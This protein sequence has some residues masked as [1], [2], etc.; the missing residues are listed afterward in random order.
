M[1]RR[2]RGILFALTLLVAAGGLIAG[3]AS[4]L[5]AQDG[6][7]RLRFAT[8]APRD[9]PVGREFQALDRELRERSNDRVRIRLYAGGAAGDERTV[10]RKLRDGQLDGAMLTAVGLGAIAREVLILQAPGL[11]TTY[12][13]L[14]RVRRRLRPELDA[15]FTR[16][17][18]TMLGWGDAGRIRLFSTQ[19]IERPADLRSARPWVWRD[20]AT[21]GAFFRAAG[22][23]GVPLGVMEVLPALST[24]MVDTVIASSVSAIA[25]QWHG[26]LRTMSRQASGVVVGGVVIKTSALA[27]IPEDLRTYL[28]E[29]S[30]SNESEFRRAGRRLDA[31]AARELSR[32]LTVVD[33]DGHR[34]A[35][36]AVAERARQ[37]LVGRLYTQAQVDR[38]RAIL[39]EP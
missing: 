5:D 23:S 21:M 2:R 37:E 24:G 16:E 39:E 32:R 27:Q 1:A 13:E 31:R 26:R 12:P 33:L 10:V 6:P 15:A 19:T 35:W 17:G 34:T 25:M 29:Q 38:V 9:S 28:R 3:D 8:L 18:F 14:D 30:V 7:L 22:A 20:S 4:E 11:I 36:Q